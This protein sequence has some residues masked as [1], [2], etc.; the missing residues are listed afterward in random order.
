MSGYFLELSHNSIPL[1]SN[2]ASDLSFVDTAWS[3][4]ISSKQ[5]NFVS[6]RV[7]R[8]DLWA[9]AYD[10]SSGITIAL[11]GRI[12][13]TATQW[14]TASHLP[15][16][17]GIACQYLL[18]AYHTRRDS[19]CRELNGAFTVF[20]IEALQSRVTIITDRMGFQPNYFFR[21]GSIQ[22]FCSHPDIL[23]K[24]CGSQLTV[25]MTSLGEVLR[26]GSCS[27]PHTYYNEVNSL[28]PGTKYVFDGQTLSKKC[29]YWHPQCQVNSS[30]RFSDLV[31]GLR[32]ALRKAVTDRTRPHLG[33]SSVLLS[34]GTDSR[35]ILYSMYSPSDAKSIT[36]YDVKNS[37]FLTAERIAIRVSS[38]HIGL[39]RDRE[40]YGNG[41][42]RAV[43]I[44]GGMWSIL[45]AHYTNLLE[46]IISL[47]LDNLF[48][49]CYADYFF[50]GLT[51]NRLHYKIYG[52]SLPL[53]KY[54]QFSFDWYAPPGSKLSEPWNENVISRQEQ[55]YS[56]IDISDTSE[57]GRWELEVRRLRPVIREPDTAGRLILLRSLPWDPIFS[58]N[59]LLDMYQRI[60]PSLKLNGK[61]W[62]KVVKSLSSKD[63]DIL[64]NNTLAKIGASSPMKL[65]GFIRG[66]ALR[67]IRGVDIDGTVPGGLL[68]RGSWP[69]FNY[70]VRHS[71]VLPNLW[72]NNHGI[73]YDV[74]C[75]LLGYDP[76][77]I[78]I[79]MWSKRSTH[80]FFRILT[81]K[82]WLDQQ[83][84]LLA[85]NLSDSVDRAQ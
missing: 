80:E 45:D 60:P 85:P 16:E 55:L 14:K 19:F 27:H 6:V 84:E 9:P 2:I 5:I 33:Q 41:A 53:Y 49:G 62:G 75:E 83:Q 3:S 15:Y 56:G 26:Y 37:E 35:A 22:I 82:L 76:W 21:S 10:S 42:V 73:S 25:D 24:H 65:L 63:L 28:D 30:D 43:K 51:S 32:T 78:S 31:D 11:V 20:V 38:Q 17:G 13:L 34:G 66:V 57:Q 36:F 44:T 39:E 40:H 69:N 79:D 54:G 12:S 72:S 64:D 4:F 67:K 81:L 48:S 7:D 50:K 18:E 71:K 1:L 59:E 23:A 29:E 58:D 68:T 8:G 70:Y 52:K 61:L 77:L 74:F 47:Q 46:D